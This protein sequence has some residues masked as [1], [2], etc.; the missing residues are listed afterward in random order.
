MGVV[1]TDFTEIRAGSCLQA[2]GGFLILNVLDLLRQPFAW[3]ALKRVIKTRSVNIEDPGEYFGFST[4]GLKPQP[5]PTEV[6]VILLGPPFIFYLLQIYENDSNKLF[7]V[8][9]DF[10]EDI[11]R[12]S[13]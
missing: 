6:K 7:K 5:I 11:P 10:D 2:N 12:D 13:R 3:D 8:R 9:A 4:T 1:Y